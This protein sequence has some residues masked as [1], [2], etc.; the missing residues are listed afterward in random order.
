MMKRRTEKKWLNFEQHLT[1]RKKLTIS[2]YYKL[3]DNFTDQGFQSSQVWLDNASWHVNHERYIHGNG[4][5]W[6][7][8]MRWEIYKLKISML[9]EL[10]ND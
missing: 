7:R 9:S 2:C 5:F 6:M 10:S 8:D 1:A 4:A 3:W